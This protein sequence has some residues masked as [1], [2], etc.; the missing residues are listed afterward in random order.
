MVS[1]LCGS[2]PLTRGA[3]RHVCDRPVPCGLIPAHAGSTS[4]RRSLRWAARAH[5]RSRGEHGDV[6]NFWQA[7]AGSSPLTR[8]AHFDQAETFHAKG[9]IPAHA[10]STLHD[11]RADFRHWAHPRSRGEHLVR[12]NRL[13]CGNGSSPLTRGA[14][15][16]CC[17]F[18]RCCR[19]IPAHAGS[20][21]WAAETPSAN[22]AHPRS[23]GEHT[24]VAVIPGLSK[25]S[26]PLTRGAQ[27]HVAGDHRTR[28]LIPAHAGSTGARRGQSPPWWAHPRSRGEHP[29]PPG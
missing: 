7:I 23:R 19:L 10:G 25:G 9:L 3:P 21:A 22:R 15:W 11:V 4:H 1:F 16:R 26:S 20:T 24:C 18:G 2:S 14:L 8:G 27:L 28:G 5:P 17:R 29:S 13:P 6:N 12:S